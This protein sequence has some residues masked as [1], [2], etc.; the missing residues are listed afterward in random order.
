[1][2]LFIKTYDSE[3]SVKRAY[4]I[5]YEINNELRRNRSKSNTYIKNITWNDE[6]HLFLIAL[7][8][9]HK[10]RYSINYCECSYETKYKKILRVIDP[11]II[12]SL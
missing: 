7:L 12:S 3:T 2:S 6:T 1:M 5:F 9:N 10:Y 4:E 11:N 8:I